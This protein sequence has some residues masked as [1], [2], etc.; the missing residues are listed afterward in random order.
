MYLSLGLRL[1]GVCVEKG[2]GEEEGGGGDGS[3]VMLAPVGCVER[4]GAEKE[5]PPSVGQVTTLLFVAAFWIFLP[6]HTVR[7]PRRD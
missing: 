7:I 1:G 5:K 2:V 3:G 6:R 4:S